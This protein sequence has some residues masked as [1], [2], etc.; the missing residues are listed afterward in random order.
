MKINPK[1]AIKGVIK[2]AGSFAVGSLVT[3]GLKQHII[4]KNTYE[5]IMVGLGSFVLTDMISTAAESYLDKQT[6][7]VYETIEKLK[8]EPVKVPNRVKI[9]E[10]FD[11]NGLPIEETMLEEE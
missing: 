2:F 11:E 3:I 10:K 4:P 5:K 9:K 6:E 1:N 8:G 7:E